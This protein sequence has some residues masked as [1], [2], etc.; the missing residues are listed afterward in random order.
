MMNKK[1]NLLVY[2][3]LFIIMLSAIAGCGYKDK[4]YLPKGKQ[5]KENNN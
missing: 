2:S 5:S 1:N 3:L 4:L